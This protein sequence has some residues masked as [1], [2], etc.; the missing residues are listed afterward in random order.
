MRKSLPGGV[1]PIGT[2]RPLPGRRPGAH[3]TRTC[4]DAFAGGDA[5]RLLTL[6]KTETIGE[7]VFA[8]V[9]MSSSPATPDRFTSVVSHK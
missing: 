5:S 3:P 2:E 8:S 9:H 6:S 7:T 1:D 4:V